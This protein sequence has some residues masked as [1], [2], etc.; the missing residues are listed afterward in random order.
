MTV[1]KTDEAKDSGIRGIQKVRGTV[2]KVDAEAEIPLSSAA[3]TSGKAYKRAVQFDL[4]DVE[5]L[6]QDSPNFQLKDNKFSFK[7]PYS[8]EKSGF[9]VKGFLSAAEAIKLDVSPESIVGKVVT[10]ERQDVQCGKFKGNN[11]VPVAVEAGETVYDKA[12][13]L[14][15]GKTAEQ[16][17]KLAVLDPDIAKDGGLKLEINSGAFLEKLVNSGR[18][19]EVDGVYQLVG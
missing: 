4:L 2:D 16:V 7:I 18:A 12:V 19:I 5:I 14:V 8:E 13:K 1:W 11:F 9:W 6:E 17:K 15:Q 10:F 3:S